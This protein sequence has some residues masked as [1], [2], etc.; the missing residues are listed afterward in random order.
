[1]IAF[2]GMESE[3]TTCR[4]MF[5]CSTDLLAYRVLRDGRWRAAE[6]KDKTEIDASASDG[7]KKGFCTP[8]S[9]SIPYTPSRAF[10]QMINAQL[11]AW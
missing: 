4:A 6:K 10:G 5:G 9:H 1:M 2:H 7:I 8:I 11:L 3:S